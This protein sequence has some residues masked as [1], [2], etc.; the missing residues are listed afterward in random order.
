MPL[1]SCLWASVHPVYPSGMSSVLFL[2]LKSYRTWK[3][4]HIPP[5]S[6]NFSWPPTPGNK[7]SECLRHYSSTPQYI[8]YFGNLL[9]SLPCG[10]V[11]RALKAGV[12]GT[13]T[14]ENWHPDLE[15]LC[16]LFPKTYLLENTRRSP[17]PFSPFSPPLLTL[18]K[19]FFDSGPYPQH[20]SEGKNLQGTKQR[21]RILM[22]E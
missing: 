22:T 17:G 2:L 11:G 10:E 15:T 4:A 13:D 19:S 20:S 12:H 14:S 6:W 7:L 1:V 9:S 21:W 18:N 3:A 16:V 5:H 8:L